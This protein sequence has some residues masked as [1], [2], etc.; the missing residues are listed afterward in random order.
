MRSRARRV[1]FAAVA[2]SSM[3]TNVLSGSKPADDGEVQ[4][5]NLL[6]AEPAPDPLVGERG[7]DVAVADDGRAAVESGPDDLGD[8]LRASGGEER[9]LRPGRSSSPCSNTCRMRSPSGVPP[10]S[11]VATTSPSC[12]SRSA[13]SL[14]WVVLP[15]P[16]R[17]SKVTNT[18]LG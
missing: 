7:V 4:L 5:Q 13:S 8:E 2:G 14:A 16:S 11:R 12:D 1:R 18:G 10:G 17:P 9:G 3:R 6:D 15:E